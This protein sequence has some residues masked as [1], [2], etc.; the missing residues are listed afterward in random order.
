[1]CGRWHEL[2]NFADN[3]CHVRHAGLHLMFGEEE[4]PLGLAELDTLAGDD[5]Q[6]TLTPCLPQTT[7]TK[8]QLS[9]AY[10]IYFQQG[11]SNADLEK[12]YGGERWFF[13]TTDS[14]MNPPVLN[15]WLLLLSMTEDQLHVLTD[16]VW[17][18]IFIFQ[19]YFDQIVTICI[20]KNI[21]LFPQLAILY[22]KW[23]YRVRQKWLSYCA[24]HEENALGQ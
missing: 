3:V 13:V 18:Q 12:I 23:Q 24:G 21:V 5:E 14:P 2:P 10:N 17:L 20:M 1:M 22:V 9:T 16:C 6:L 19:L 7:T 15:S 4:V 8:F 11:I